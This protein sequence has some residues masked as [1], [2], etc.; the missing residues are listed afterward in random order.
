MNLGQ[1][2]KLFALNAAKLII[3]ANDRGWGITL[4]EAHR[5]P[6]QAALNAKTGAGISNSLHCKR[7]AIDLNLFLGDRWFTKSEDYRALGEYWKTLDPL[8]CWGGDFAKPDGNHFSM[9]HEGV[10]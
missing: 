3:W 8:N 10:K 1:K 6:E 4:G 7:L 5:P 2:Q 9:S